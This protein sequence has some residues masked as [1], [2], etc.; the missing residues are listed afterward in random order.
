MPLVVVLVT[1]VK[2][3]MGLIWIE[4]FVFQFV[5]PEKLSIGK[6]LHTAASACAPRAMGNYAATL[7]DGNKA[8][9]ST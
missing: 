6:L 9:P 2:K 4:Q 3:I 8:T 5:I 7:F 1:V